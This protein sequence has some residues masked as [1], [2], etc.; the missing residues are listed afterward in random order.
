MT[1]NNCTLTANSS[2]LAGGGGAIVNKAVLSLINCTFATNTSF[3]GA[4]IYNDTTGVLHLTNTIL[5]D[6][7]TSI[8]NLHTTNGINDLVDVTNANLA[9]LGY[10]GGLTQTM[11][12][13]SG[14]A[15][16]DAGL[17]SVTNFL[18]TDQRG[19]PRLVGAHVDI[20]AVEVQTNL[21]V[22]TTADSGFGSLPATLAAIGSGGTVTISP[23]LSGQAVVLT[24]GPITVNNSVTVDG[25]ALARP[26][27][28]DGDAQSTVLIVNPGVTATL[29]S[30]IITNGVDNT[31]SLAGGIVNN[32]SLT[33][34]DCTFAGN[35]ENI[36]DG[37]GGGLQNNGGTLVVNNSIFSNNISM[38]ADGGGGGAISTFG[39][40]VALNQCTFSGNSATGDGSWGG[41][42]YNNSSMTLTNCTVSGN[43]TGD[44]GAGI[45]SAGNGTSLELDNCTVSRNVATNSGGDPD[46]GGGIFNFFSPLTLNNCTI[47]NNSTTNGDGG[48]IYNGDGATLIVNNCTIAGNSVTTGNGGG[49]L[50]TNN[51]GTVY[52]TNTIVAGNTAS[53]S[54]N[55]AGAF[56]GTDN[57]TSGNPLLL[58][59]GNYGGPTE[60]MPPM[61]D[62]PV[63]DVG[64]DEVTNFLATDQRGYPRLS[65]AHVDIGA[66]EAQIPTLT[67]TSPTGGET[68]SNLT[69]TASGTANGLDAVAAVYVMDS[70]GSPVP[71]TTTDNWSNWTAMVMLT[72]L[73]NTLS[74]YAVSSNGIP[75]PTNS[76]SFTFASTNFTTVTNRN[77]PADVLT[78]LINDTGPAKSPNRVTPLKD[79]AIVAVS[80]KVTLTA[81]PGHNWIF[82]NWVFGT[83]EPYSTTNTPVLKFVMESN[84]IAEANFVTNPFLSALG[85]YYG[86]FAPTNGPRAQTNSGAIT[87]SVTQ[88]GSLSGKIILGS[89]TATLAGTFNAGGSATV[90]G[91]VHGKSAFTA[92]LQ[93]DFSNQLATGTI[94]NA[95]F[96]SPLLA[97][98]NPFSAKNKA[99]NFAGQYTLIIPGTNITAIGPLGNSYAT[100]KISTTGAVT[101]SGALADNTPITASSAVSSNGIW[102]LYLSLYK[103]NGSFWSWNAFDPDTVVSSNDVPVTN[104]S[105]SWINGGNTIHGALYAAGFTNTNAVI[106]GSTYV[107]TDHPVLSDLVGQPV[108]IEGG[109]LAVILTNTLADSGAVE[110][111]NIVLTLNKTTGAVTGQFLDGT[112]K[113]K[114]NGVLLQLQT[115]VAGFF[116]GTNT[117][118]LFQIAP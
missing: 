2:A 75:S 96:N 85:T 97:N 42:I 7:T 17:D 89:A 68:F 3:N 104:A 116:P 15:A 39:G 43:S 92:D 16:I 9:P 57:F 49:I 113:V 66:V 71:A 22:T 73:A 94:S 64:D 28:L 40:T 112:K 82:S 69:I 23:S 52:L 80:N 12:P 106:Y 45:F 13:L 105:P 107:S 91:K 62:S 41:A 26:L 33:I 61:A 32:G 58:P 88:T 5:A 48:G 117:S 6:T 111:S 50:I 76:V 1:L 84:F 46:G 27:R 18:A 63:I 93:L 114:V 37:G 81:V 14:S 99:T 118:G 83:S 30:L 87:F 72:P 47:A 35:A 31:G 90:P 10:Y 98:L 20:G 54:N 44:R 60:T 110:A 108:I 103:G 34:N 86:L 79:G 77:E 24:S 36:I 95:D 102:P 67:I 74:A 65:G 59:L 8:E 19:F 55:V 100:V 11:P 115:N 51:S 56:T 53:S 4:S 109:N 29:N 21:V 25:S 101:V 70:G 38:A 78:I